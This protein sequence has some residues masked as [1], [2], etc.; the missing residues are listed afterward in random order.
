MLC[1]FILRDILSI[2]V[3]AGA[4]IITVGRAVQLISH[5]VSVGGGPLASVVYVPEYNHRT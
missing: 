1:W 3:K 5:V 4:Y 2:F